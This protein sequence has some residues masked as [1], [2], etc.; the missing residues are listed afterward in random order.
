[1]AHHRLGDNWYV[2]S[3]TEDSNIIYEKAIIN[4]EVIFIV[5]M[6]YPINQKEK[7]DEMVTRIATT[8]EAGSKN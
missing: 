6:T 8:F 4:D 1:M 3:Y 7:Y 2:V 5:N